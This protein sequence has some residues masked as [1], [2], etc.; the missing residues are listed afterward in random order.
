MVGQE[1]YT[2]RDTLNPRAQLAANRT[3]T[4][5]LKGE[6][7]HIQRAVADQYRTT[8]AQ[9]TLVYFP[10]AGHIIYDDQPDRYRAAIRAFLRDQL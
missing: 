3:P 5:I 9:S 2:K 7:D 6:C 10:P 8:F 1:F 4:L